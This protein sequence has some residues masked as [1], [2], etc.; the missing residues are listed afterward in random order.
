M[1]DL[2]NKKEQLQGALQKL[3]QRLQEHRQAAQELVTRQTAKSEEL[4]R[5][6]EE[7]EEA[8][9]ALDANTPPAS[10]EEKAG[11]EP[12]NLASFGGKR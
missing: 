6:T 7:Y 4:A 1:L 11:Q 8:L 2:A 3:E 5:V 9:R 10:Q 12:D